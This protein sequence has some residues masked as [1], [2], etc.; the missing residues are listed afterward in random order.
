[1]SVRISLFTVVE[2]PVDS[3]GQEALECGEHR[4]GLPERQWFEGR[5]GPSGGVWSGGELQVLV[6]SVVEW[7]GTLGGHLKDF[8]YQAGQELDVGAVGAFEG[9]KHQTDVLKFVLTC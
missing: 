9:S 3:E 7:T 4:K 2:L 8:V 6:S 1:M 5:P